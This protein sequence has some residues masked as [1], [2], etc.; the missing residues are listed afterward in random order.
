VL[1]LSGRGKEALAAVFTVGEEQHVE[2]SVAMRAANE[3]EGR[4]ATADQRSRS[5]A[6]IVSRV[7]MLSVVV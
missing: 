1:L 2:E 7:F 6:E 4:R 3:G 5:A